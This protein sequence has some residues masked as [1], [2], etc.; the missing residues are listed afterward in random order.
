MDSCRQREADGMARSSTS[1]LW[2]QGLGSRLDIS[3]LGPDHS[4]SHLPSRSRFTTDPNMPPSDAHGDDTLPWS[5]AIRNGQVW[6]VW[7]CH[8]S[9]ARRRF[10]LHATREHSQGGARTSKRSRAAHHLFAEVAGLVRAVHVLGPHEAGIMARLT[11]YLQQH[12]ARRIPYTDHTF[13]V[14]R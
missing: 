10:T 2:E 12:N 11:A 6:V 1:R 7:P 9:G 3:L 14:L 8:T 5:G 4:A 13:T